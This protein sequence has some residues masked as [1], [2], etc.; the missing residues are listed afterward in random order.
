MKF[1]NVCRLIF[2]LAPLIKPPYTLIDWIPTPQSTPSLFSL[3]TL[4]QPRDGTINKTSMSEIKSKHL[5]NLN[6]SE[7]NWFNCRDDQLLSRSN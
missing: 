7:R 3:T 2:D 4:C 1:V 5:Q 6:K